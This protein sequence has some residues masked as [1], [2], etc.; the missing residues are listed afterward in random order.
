MY[1]LLSADA[2]QRRLLRE[3]REA[4]TPLMARSEPRRRPERTYSAP[5][6]GIARIKVEG[7]LTPT[8]DIMAEVYGEP[9]TTYPDLQEQLATALDDEAV[10]EI[11]WDINSPGGSVDGYHALID[12]IAAAR[13]AKLMRV[14]A[15]EAQSAA[16][17]IAAAVGRITA[18]SRVAPVGSV[19]V[20]TS[21][22]IQG[23]L[24]GEVV[25]ITNTDSPD[26]RPNI[27]TPEGRAVVVEY[28][29]QIAAEFMSGIA[30]GRAAAT[31][32]AVSVADVAEGY[33]RGASMLATRAKRMGLIDAIASRP[34]RVRTDLTNA[35][36]QGTVPN[37]MSQSTTPPPAEPTPTEPAQ[38]APAPVDP[39]VDVDED[40]PE[41]ESVQTDPAPAAPPVA[42]VAASAA[43]S[44]TE[45]AELAA[46]R[47][48][49]DAQVA[50]ERRAL[51]TALVEVGAETPAT[52]WAK[53]APVARLASEPI[54][55]LRA[56][57]AA[58]RAVRPVGLTPPA[59]QTDD[60]L[61]DFERRDA[62]KIKD[63]EA[64]ARFVASRIARKQKAL[65]NHG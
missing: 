9:N 17:G 32:R 60:A 36:T 44:P 55:A 14:E 13:G 64:R 61:E 21:G 8:P 1:W 29:D 23:G 47:A 19:G 54:E 37:C 43:L 59:T 42:A 33:G 56:R 4:R 20:A 24:C 45:R 62:A 16:Y 35:R 26:K 18:N 50:V 49:R 39:A 51:V 30:E 48:A 52:A 40:A 58:L 38:A 10:T 22:F 5:V 65:N 57:V 15:S 28:L 41:S 31:G 7:V 6:D 11:V 27:K 3:I 53:G 2:L 46:F 34:A 63:P 12:D 25:D